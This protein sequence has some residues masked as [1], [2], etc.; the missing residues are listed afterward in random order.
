MD[1]FRRHAQAAGQV[2]DIYVDVGDKVKAGQL[3][4]KMDDKDA[5]ANLPHA[6]STLQAAELAVSDIDH[7]GTQDER[8]TYAADMSR[9][10]TCSASRM[11]A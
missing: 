5:L 8:N 4:L 3:L 1:D 9:A 6:N 10:R 2:Q 11:R 7:G